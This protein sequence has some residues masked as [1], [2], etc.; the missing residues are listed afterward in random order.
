MSNV[1]EKLD[2]YQIM[3]NLLPG[4][5]IGI[6]LEFIL[7]MGI[8][9]P[10][11]TEKI[12]IYYFIGL[13]LNRIGSLVVNPILKKCRVIVEAPYQEYVKAVKEDSRID[14]LSET[15]NY[16][17]TLL[18]GTILLL[19][20]YICMNSEIV[21]K[22]LVSNWRCSSLVC[23]IVLFVFAYRKQTDYVRRCVEAVNSQEG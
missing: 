5:F 18:A 8:T 15:N 13:I 19:I 16:F 17:R 2:S 12:V 20:L 22:W 6:A 21:W 23:L 3:T 1:I 4:T 7:G 11:V 14:I 9:S 10:S